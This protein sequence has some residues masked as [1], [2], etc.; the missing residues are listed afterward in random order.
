[1]IHPSPELGSKSS[2][3]ELCFI[4]LSASLVPERRKERRKRRRRRGRRRE[5]ERNKEEEGAAVRPFSGNSAR[6]RV[7]VGLEEDEG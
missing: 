2:E 7:Q 5:G 6:A 4:H 3:Q 1:M